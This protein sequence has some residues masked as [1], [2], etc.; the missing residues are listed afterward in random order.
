MEIRR[1][2]SLEGGFN[3]GPFNPPRCCGAQ[4]IQT[5]GGW[6]VEKEGEVTLAYSRNFLIE[7]KKLYLN[8]PCK[9]VASLWR[10]RITYT[11]ES[12]YANSRQRFAF[13]AGARLENDC[14]IP[15]KDSTAVRSIV[16]PCTVENCGNSP[17]Y[18]ILWYIGTLPILAIEIESLGNFQRFTCF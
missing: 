11:A 16:R 4:H 3:A 9:S 8:G 10:C 6:V 7:E 2:F 1:G 13:P 15:A 5:A 12:C 18:R 14:S 17:E